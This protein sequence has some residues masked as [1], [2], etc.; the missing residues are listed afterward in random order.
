M[1]PPITDGV[2]QK[3]DCTT[4]W[5]TE[6]LHLWEAHL[7]TT[8]EGYRK[9]WVEK[10]SRNE[11]TMASPDPT[12]SLR[13]NWLAR[14]VT[15]WT[16]ITGLSYLRMNQSLNVDH[17]RTGSDPGWM[18]LCPWNNP[19]MGLYWRP[20]VECMPRSW[21][22]IFPEE[23]CPPKNHW[24]AGGEPQPSKDKIRRDREV[25]SR[26]M[27][28]SRVEEILWIKVETTGEYLLMGRKI[29]PQQWG[30]GRAI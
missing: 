22:N 5:P 24:R 1:K 21:A 12:G 3:A 20:S 2:S 4:L 26:Y 27:M 25:V 28:S 23:T 14:I 9:E 18:A 7:K 13:L 15:C 6:C 16:E 30:V 29:S 17:S 19:W 8:E 11:P 10:S